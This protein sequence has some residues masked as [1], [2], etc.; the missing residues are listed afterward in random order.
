MRLWSVYKPGTSIGNV[1]G[2]KNRKVSSANN[3]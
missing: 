3:P 1:G 2:T